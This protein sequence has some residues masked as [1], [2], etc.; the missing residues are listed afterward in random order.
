MIRVKW[1][2]NDDYIC[3]K[4]YWEFSLGR[5]P[6]KTIEHLLLSLKKE[7]PKFP[8][9]SLRMKLQNIKQISIE[10]GLKDNVQL[11]PLDQYSRQC[12]DAFKQV[13]KELER[14]PKPDPGPKPKTNTSLFTD[15]II[16]HVKYGIGYVIKVED[17][18]VSARF[19][20]KTVLLEA[21]I[22]F[23]KLFRFKDPYLNHLMETI[24][25]TGEGEYD[26]IED[27]ELYK[28]VLPE[29]ERAVFKELKDSNLI[30]FCYM[31]W[32]YKKRILKE[33]YN[34]NWHSPMDLSKQHEIII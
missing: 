17:T 6:Q 11:S 25:N 16:L 15:A 7:L 32:M 34:I 14:D 26:P 29:I 2:Y 4:R 13:L 27:T 9:G 22:A 5:L 19:T 28:S 24:L 10:L 30:E 23:N 20:E 18:R 31:Y 3:C 12:K 21:S 1:N 33:K 8:I